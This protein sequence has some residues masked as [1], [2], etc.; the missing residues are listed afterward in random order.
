MDL[1]PGDEVYYTPEVFGPGSNGGY[2]EYHVAK[3]EKAWTPSWTPPGA[4]RSSTAS[5]PPGRSSVS[6]RFWGRR[7]TSRPAEVTKSLGL[8]F[9]AVLTDSG[10]NVTLSRG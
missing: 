9:R 5:P 4:R 10:T 7:A 2:A 1:S 8:R 3:A 6:R